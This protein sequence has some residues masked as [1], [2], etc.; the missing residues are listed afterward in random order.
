MRATTWIRVALGATLLSVSAPALARAPLGA[1]VNP[2]TTAEARQMYKAY[3]RVM[4]RFG[5][6][7]TAE[8]RA[9]MGKAGILRGEAGMSKHEEPFVTSFRIRHDA[10]GRAYATFRLQKFIL[11][12]P[13]VYLPAVPKP[14]ELLWGKITDR[15]VIPISKGQEKALGDGVHTIWKGI[16]PGNR[17]LAN[18]L[19]VSEELRPP[20]K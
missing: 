1:V 6:Y 20:M 16:N 19:A 14:Y 17:Y 12:D 11:T 8:Q 10:S 13:G 5:N 2:A 18:W 9:V 3:K 7:F 4:Y 15:V